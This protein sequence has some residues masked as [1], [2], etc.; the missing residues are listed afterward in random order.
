LRSQIGSALALQL[1][2]GGTSRIRT[3]RVV[4]DSE[5]D[6]RWL[7]GGMVGPPFSAAELKGLR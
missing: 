3:A 1:A 2:A 6:G 4:H 5:A 7:I